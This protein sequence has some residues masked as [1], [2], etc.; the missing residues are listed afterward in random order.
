MS[1]FHN[2]ARVVVII[3]GLLMLLAEIGLNIVPLIAAAGIAGLAIA[4]G[5]QNLIRD[6]FYG[7]TILLENQY[8]V[9]DVVRVA[10]ISGMVERVTRIT[11]G[12]TWKA[13]S[14]CAAWRIK[15][16][17]NTHGW[18]RACSS[19]WPTKRSEQR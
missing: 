19:A 8:M 11:C 13:W 3:G 14:T 7:F 4:F 9:N 2:T 6:Y 18:S 5:A 10:G 15:T 12:G 17:S 1:V 16:V